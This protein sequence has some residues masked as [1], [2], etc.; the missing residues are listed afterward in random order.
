MK[1]AGVRPKA[2]FAAKI[3]V[4][5]L[6]FIPGMIV[7]ALLPILPVIAIAQHHKFE[8]PEQVE[9]VVA[10]A[11]MLLTLVAVIL[12]LIWIARICKKMAEKY[13]LQV[14]SALLKIPLLN[15]IWKRIG[16]RVDFTR[17]GIFHNFFISAVTGKSTGLHPCRETRKLGTGCD[18]HG[19]MGCCELRCKFS[20]YA[21][22]GD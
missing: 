9:N 13:D 14:S 6:S 1:F 21:H 16:V 7:A 17:V 20:K 15:V 11:V 18:H 8:D 19:C 10:S 5:S 22:C 4:A 12:P 2:E 3:V